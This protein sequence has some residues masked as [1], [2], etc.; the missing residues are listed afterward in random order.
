ME[1]YLIDIEP[2]SQLEQGLQVA[3]ASYILREE[4]KKYLFLGGILH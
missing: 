2:F 4:S 1:Y 3:V